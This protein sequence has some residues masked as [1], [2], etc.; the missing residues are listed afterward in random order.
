MTMLDTRPSLTITRFMKAPPARVFA[1][2]TDPAKLIGWFGPDALPTLSAEVDLRPGGKYSIVFQT[3]NC[4]THNAHG[5]YLE[6]VE[7]ERLVF[8]WR[9]ISFPERESLVTLTFKP[10]DGG[11]EFTLL[12][13]KLFDEEVRDSHIK[14]WTACLVKLEA[15]VAG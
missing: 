2:W 1:A 6:V 5:E 15:F 13:E 10:V 14:G 4:E 9:W 8:T 7:N 11:T 3:L 12:H